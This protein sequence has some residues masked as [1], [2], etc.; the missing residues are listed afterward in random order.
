MVVII[1][2]RI[3]TLVTLE[4]RPSDEVF[5]LNVAQ[6]HRNIFIIIKLIQPIVKITTSIETTIDSPDDVP[7]K[8]T[9]YTSTFTKI[10]IILRVYI[11]FKIKPARSLSDLKQGNRSN[12]AKHFETLVENDSFIIHNTHKEHSLGFLIN[13][14]LH[15]TLW[16]AL[17]GRVQDQLMF[18]DKYNEERQ[19]T[20]H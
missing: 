9:Q 17:H 4:V 13:M 12:M 19:G 3:T 10:T 2:K 18:I 16:E 15:V 1:N 7:S 11:P 14:N 6:A 5:N 8:A 20:N